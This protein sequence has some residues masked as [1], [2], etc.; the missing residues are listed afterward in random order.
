MAHFTA[1]ARIA[2]NARN[3]YLWAR[4]VMD[5]EPGIRQRTYELTAPFTFSFG[6]AELAFTHL[7][8][9]QFPER[10]RRSG[11][12]QPATQLVGF[13]HD[14]TDTSVAHDAYVLETWTGDGTS[15]ADALL[16]AEVFGPEGSGYRIW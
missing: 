3:P 15:E 7:A 8:V 14:P 4:L 5:R 11:D 16:N 10:V 6:S 2:T 1:P 13:V 12:G 9:W